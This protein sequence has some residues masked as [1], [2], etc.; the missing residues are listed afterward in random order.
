MTTE[1]KSQK[2]P[3]DEPEPMGAPI[4]EPPKVE[5]SE[6]IPGEAIRQGSAA[7][8][9]P[10]TAEPASEAGTP[11]HNDG[12]PLQPHQIRSDGTPGAEPPIVDGDEPAAKKSAKKH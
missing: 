10:R 6:P 8:T 5:V 7:G 4:V 9:T 3:Q 2:P 11:V 12:T 1:K